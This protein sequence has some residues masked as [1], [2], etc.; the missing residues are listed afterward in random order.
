M[1]T[2]KFQ[3]NFNFQNLLTSSTFGVRSSVFSVFSSLLYTYLDFRKLLHNFLGFSK[4]FHFCTLYNIFVHF[5]SFLLFY[6]QTYI[7]TINI[8]NTVC[9]CHETGL[10]LKRKLGSICICFSFYN[11][12]SELSKGESLKLKAANLL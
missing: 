1:H 5:L 7:K 10:S 6:L 2:N 8:P 3:H 4:V 12:C 9:R 11:N